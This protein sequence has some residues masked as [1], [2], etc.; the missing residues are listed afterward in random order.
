MLKTIA[1]E[2]QVALYGE[3]IAVIMFNS[4]KEFVVIHLALWVVSVVMSEE[5]AYTWIRYTNN[6]EESG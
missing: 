1:K 3:S 2:N 5:F 6:Q 4:E